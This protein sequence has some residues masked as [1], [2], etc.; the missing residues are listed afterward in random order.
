MKLIPHD[1]VGTYFNRDS[2]ALW[3]QDD[4]ALKG[5]RIILSCECF[6]HMDKRF[7][8]QDKPN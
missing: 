3:Y 5:N 6:S 4:G 7:L 8:Q 1:F 2:L